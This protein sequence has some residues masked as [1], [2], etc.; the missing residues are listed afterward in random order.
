MDVI[1]LKD[2]KELGSAG[3]VVSVK[4]G[5]ARNKL[6]P[7]GIALRASKRNRAISEEKR[8]TE[9]NRKDRENA[10]FDSL[11]KVLSK[12][13]ITIEAQVG[14]EDKM[15]G[16]ITVTDVQKALQEKG[17]SV[18]RSAILLP[19]PIKALGIYHIS[20]KVATEKIGDV[21]LYVIKS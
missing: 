12:T 15:F 14:D 7:E 19:E 6:I 13:E 8:T 20:V 18:E 21:K 11:L 17:V 10:S 16:S 2:Y 9:L 3:D 5:Y 4:P 1:L